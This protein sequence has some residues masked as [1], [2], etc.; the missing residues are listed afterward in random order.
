MKG[1]AARVGKAVVASAGLDVAIAYGAFLVIALFVSLLGVGAFMDANLTL[2]DLLA[3][4]PA[5][6]ALG[7]GSGEGVLLVLFAGATILVPWLWKNRLAPLAFAV[8]LLFTAAAFRPLVEQH[9]AQQEALEG[10]GE[11][12]VAITSLT[13]A[14]AARAG[15]LDAL[16]IGAW[17]LFAT[18][19]YLALRGV[20][21]VGARK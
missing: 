14:A 19:I 18:V 9:R 10:L 5:T 3:G 15:P 6:T 21:R 20:A 1:E 16:G 17:L 8:P 11:L 4:D 12:G 7:G 2:A 13:P